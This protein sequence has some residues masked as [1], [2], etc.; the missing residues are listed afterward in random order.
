M[1]SDGVLS[2]FG[3]GVIERRILPQAAY[4]QAEVRGAVLGMT[5]R[6]GLDLNPQP[7]VG[8]VYPP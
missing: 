5:A 7:N 3:P 6:P 4:A 8:E 1:D 2:L